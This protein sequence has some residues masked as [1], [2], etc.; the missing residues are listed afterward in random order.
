MKLKKTMTV[1]VGLVFAII[2]SFGVSLFLQSKTVDQQAQKII[3]LEKKIELLVKRYNAPQ[4]QKLTTGIPNIKL[5]HDPL[6]SVTES[7]RTPYTPP[8][9]SHSKA[10]IVHKINGV[11]TITHKNK[12]ALLGERF[13]ELISAASIVP[14]IINGKFEGFV[15]K[16]I[17]PNSIF[18]EF[19]LQVGD[20]VK[21]I[22]GQE[23]GSIGQTNTLL[24][25]LRQDEEFE[26]EIS[27]QGR[28]VM[29]QIAIK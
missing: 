21:S 5:T 20:V 29:M 8:K 9:R 19:D 15:F 17:Q 11:Y 28:M 1:F 3:E 24:G 23:L 2:V 7:S 18:T 25:N 22:N 16:T 12:S 4:S 10:R 26:V 13:G 6:V 14:N 27:R